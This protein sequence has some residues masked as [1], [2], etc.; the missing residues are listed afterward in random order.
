MSTLDMLYACWSSALK[1]CY[2]LGLLFFVVNLQRGKLFS[3]LSTQEAEVSPT[4]APVP[5]ISRGATFAGRAALACW[6]GGL[7]PRSH[8]WWTWLCQ[9]NFPTLCY[10]PKFSKLIPPHMS[11]F[12]SLKYILFS[13]SLMNVFV[14]LLEGLN[15]D[16][17]HFCRYV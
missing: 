13:H 7:N 6:T 3:A 10:F 14:L 11:C 17:L 12:P 1:W 8:S 15:W 2:S 4:D 16:W 9:K 5:L